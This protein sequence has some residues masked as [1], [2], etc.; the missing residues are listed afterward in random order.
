MSTTADQSR[1]PPVARGMNP[2]HNE[3]MLTPPVARA[4]NPNHNETLLK[5]ARLAPSV[6]GACA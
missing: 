6:R 2:N 4:L 3:T 5:L 1:P